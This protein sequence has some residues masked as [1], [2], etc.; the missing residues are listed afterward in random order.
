MRSQI[1][2]VRFGMTNRPAARQQKFLEAG[3]GDYLYSLQ[4]IKKN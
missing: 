1:S 2:K 3:S 4:R